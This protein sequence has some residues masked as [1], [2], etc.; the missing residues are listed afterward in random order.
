MYKKE[1]DE[2]IYNAQEKTY[3]KIMKPGL[4]KKI[5]YFFKI[6]K[7]PG[8]NIKYISEILK[9][10]GIKTFEIIEYSN[11]K[12]ITKEILGNS[13]TEEILKIKEKEK[14]KVLINKYVEIVAKIIE[15]GIYFGDFNY[16]NFIVN[17]G[18]LFVIDLEDYRKD[19]FFIF[20]KNKMM[21]RLK[22]KLIYMEKILNVHNKYVNGERIYQQIEKRLEKNK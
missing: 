5:K 20:R 11:Y 4:N 17:D 8:Q 10:N 14:V 16:Y 6:R 19:I 12:V 3:T 15:L 2:I 18:E 13:L 7:Y 21:K 9:K 22:E 1:K